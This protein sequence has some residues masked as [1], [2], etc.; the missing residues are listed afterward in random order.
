[1]LLV[2]EHILFQFFY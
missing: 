2:E 1:M